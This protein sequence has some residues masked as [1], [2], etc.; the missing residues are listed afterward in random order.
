[1]RSLFRQI[2]A[3]FATYGSLVAV[4][5][6]VKPAGEGFSNWQ[7]GLLAAATLALITDV[8]L[9]IWEYSRRPERRFRPGPRQKTRIR[10]FMFDWI[11]SAG[12]VAIFTRDLT[13]VDE[14]DQELMQLLQQKARRSELTVVLPEHTGLTRDL[15]STGAK[16]VTYPTLDYTIQSRFTLVN[17]G[18]AGARVAVGH[19]DDGAHIIRI[20]GSDDPS[21]YLAEDLVEIVKRV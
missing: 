21:F 12:R 3:G 18:R 16:I 10:D 6:T 5:Y 9:A 17:V 13:W 15:E 7:T 2:L 14:A 20:A 11:G 8:G 4:V 1:M 19:S